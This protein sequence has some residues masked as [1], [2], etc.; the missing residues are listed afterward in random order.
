LW[1]SK[2]GVVIKNMSFLGMLAR[3]WQNEEKRSDQKES[4][5]LG[6]NLRHASCLRKEKPGTF[7]TLFEKARSRMRN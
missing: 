7:P 4:K 1:D 6:R 3:D 2:A 5:D